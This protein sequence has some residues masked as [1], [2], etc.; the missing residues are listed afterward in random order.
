MMIA[1]TSSG[2]VQRVYEIMHARE[3]ANDK[4]AETMQRYTMQ[5]DAMKMR[6]GL[7]PEQIAIAEQRA[8]AIASYNAAPITNPR[9]PGDQ[10]TMALVRQI[11][12]DYDDTKY[13]AK[14]TGA[15]AEARTGATRSANLDLI[16]RSAEAAIPQAVAAS[17]ALPRGRFVPINKLLQMGDTQISDPALKTFKQA[18]L[19]LA[20]LW[21]RAMNPTGVM[22]ESDRE[23]ALG[24]LSTADSPETYRTVVGNLKTFLQRERTAVQE[25]R[26]GKEPG[27]GENIATP[28]SK[29]E[30]DALPSGTQFTAP[31]GTVRTKP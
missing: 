13:A 6:A 25:F 5:T 11:N 27:G 23:M 12:P 4:I 29:A 20:E 9:Q 19:Q 22:R 26:Q 1:A 16:M 14:K 10:Y 8:Q 2:N 3:T 28:K 24:I 31:D 18:N 30:Y 7:Q 15:T 17:D 21:A